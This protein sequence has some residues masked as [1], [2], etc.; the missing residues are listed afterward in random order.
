MVN[1]NTNS[2]V[3]QVRVKK[4]YVCFLCLR[5]LK[6]GTESKLLLKKITPDKMGRQKLILSS[7]VAGLYTHT[8]SIK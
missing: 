7:T 8:Q 4:Q 5:I 6:Y 2:I 1:T 3:V